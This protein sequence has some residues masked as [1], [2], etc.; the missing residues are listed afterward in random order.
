MGG[1]NG[2]FP[3]ICTD[4]VALLPPVSMVAQVHA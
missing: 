4:R 2:D 3:E 1:S